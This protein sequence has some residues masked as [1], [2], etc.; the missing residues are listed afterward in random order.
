M[1]EPRYPETVYLVRLDGKGAA[2]TVSPA[3]AEGWRQAG[4]DV[5]AYALVD[6]EMSVRID[7][8]AKALLQLGDTVYGGSAWTSALTLVEQAIE[9]IDKPVALIKADLA[10]PT[11]QLEGAVSMLEVLPASSVDKP[12]LI[13][14]LVEVIG[15]LRFARGV[16]GPLEEGPK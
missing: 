4:A 8:Y 3:R 12:T 7:E 15:Q 14:L 6:P 16:P 11:G 1:S 2:L 5:Q 10:R 13:A 9:R